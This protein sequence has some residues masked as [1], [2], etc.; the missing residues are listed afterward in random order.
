ME[1]PPPERQSPERAYEAFERPKRSIATLEVSEQS[2]AD[3]LI[4]LAETAGYSAAHFECNCQCND[5][6][7]LA[8]QR[9]S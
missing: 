8:R 7:V 9:A 5:A 3:S 6:R 2:D 1:I 4:D